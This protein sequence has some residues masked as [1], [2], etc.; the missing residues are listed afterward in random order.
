MLRPDNSRDIPKMTKEVANACFPKGNIYIK[1]RDEIGT[2]FVDEQFW[3]LFPPQGQPAMSPWRLA[4]ITVMQFMEGLSDRQAVDSVAAR[5]DWKY[6]LG[7]E[8]TSSSFDNSVLSEFR[9]RLL[10]GSP[11]K[12][13]LDTLLGI[14]EERKWIRKRGAIRTDSTHVLGAIRATNRIV[15]AEETLRYA[16][17]GLANLVPEWLKENVPPEWGHLYIRRAGS[18]RMPKG[19]KERLEIA[20]CIGRDGHWLLDM[21]FGDDNVS[22]LRDTP[23]I[24]ILR[25]VWIQQYYI[26][27]DGEVIYREKKSLGTTNAL[28]F[29]SSPYDLDARYAKK[30]TTSWIGYKAHITETC[31]TD[32]PYL[33]TNVST[34]KGPVADTKKVGAI[35]ENL[36]DEGR[37]PDAHLVDMGYISSQN[38]LQS[39]KI[40]GV[41]LIGPIRK[42]EKWQA[43]TESGFALSDFDIDIDGQRAICPEGKECSSWARTIDNGKD[44]VKIKFSS[45]DCRVCKSRHLCTKSTRRTLTL[46]KPEEYLAILKARKRAKN[47]GFKNV[48][49]RR[50]GIEATISWATRSFGLRKARYSGIE[51]TSLQH[52]VIATALNL[53]RIYYWLEERERTDTRISA[54]GRLMKGIK[55]QAA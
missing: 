6:L 51:K 18:T 35:H 29:I 44:T 10:N 9:T 41:D 34:T 7:L 11:E 40:Y 53:N 55:N 48:Y 20:T 45:K 32:L 24:E 15:C 27:D 14:C 8:L 13:F 38:L 30:F 1:L 16:L 43:R 17:N 19:T 49:N 47:E 50:A 39:E 5:I 22:W 33:I 26:H 37:L 54:F 3:K 36:K 12:I 21:V 2:L 4:L 31:D 23:M 42:D 28:D 52:V 46:R 25:R